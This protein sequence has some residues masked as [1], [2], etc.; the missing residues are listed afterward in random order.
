MRKQCKVVLAQLNMVLGGIEKN[1]EKVIAAS[2]DAR[3]N[4]SADIIVFPELTLTGYPPE[5]LLFR[6]DLH[7][8]LEAALD[9]ITRTVTGITAVIGHPLLL[10]GLLYNCL[11]YTSPSPRDS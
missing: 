4:L 6:S 2:I 11:L 9:Q 8:R 5:D 1:T 7:R 10:K 3:E